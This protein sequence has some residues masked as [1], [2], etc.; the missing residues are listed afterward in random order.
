MSELG[1]LLPALPCHG[2]INFKDIG[3][4]TGLAT[5]E[6]VRQ[7]LGGLRSQRL[8][9]TLS[10]HLQDTP[11]SDWTSLKHNLEELAEEKEVAGLSFIRRSM[12]EGDEKE[13]G[14]YHL[15]TCN[16]A[17]HWQVKTQPAKEG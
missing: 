12:Y 3:C 8:P 10:L 15:I 16:T 5:E 9:A 4:A 13:E 6:M 2:Q 1:T 7:V 14:K 17:A 11:E